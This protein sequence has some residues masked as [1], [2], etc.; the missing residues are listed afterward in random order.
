MTDLTNPL[1]QLISTPLTSLAD[2][3]RFWSSRTPHRPYL[4]SPTANLSYGEVWDRVAKIACFLRAD[5]KIQN[6]S[7]LAICVLNAEHSIYFIWASLALGICLAFV[8]Q[9]RDPSVL[10]GHMKTAGATLLLTDIPML[11]DSPFA[12]SV[13][14]LLAAIDG[15]IQRP[16]LSV[17]PASLARSP[18]FILP[19][20]GTMGE[21]K[22]V[23]LSQGQFL[24]SIL[25]LYRMGQLDRAVDRF[26]YI[27]PPLSHSYGLSTFLEYSFSGSA[28][29]VASDFSPLRMMGELAQKELSQQ[30]TALEGVPDFYRLLSKFANKVRLPALH[31][32]GCGGGALD[33]AAVEWLS[34]VYPTLSCSIRYG[35]T[36][37]PSVVAYNVVT[38]PYA[39]RWPISG[40]VLPIYEV[41]IVGESGQPLPEG[42]EGEIWLKGECLGLPYLGDRSP[43]SEY[44]ATGDLGYFDSPQS[45]VVT[46]R[47]SLF[48]KHKG[49]RLS[50]EQIESV[51]AGL[52]GILDCRV[53]SQNSELV[54]EVVSPNH[55]HTMEEIVAFLTA[56]LPPYAIPSSIR[57][58]ERLPR[59]AS[60]KLERH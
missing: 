49:F 52:A 19:T 17:A 40:K 21:P 7:V 10:Q 59:T 39:D 28:I 55:A 16:A 42:Q 34:S 60:G 58:V 12:Y 14:D 45:L 37:T 35:L 30:I 26:V 2:I 54:A 20:S 15:E 38:L 11:L 8:P 25:A 56:R 13:S 23:Q 24:Q 41:L 29:A 36:E 6:E 31:H 46:G 22:W 44:F 5:P 50:P 51:L 9:T 43:Q 47:K 32:I 48:I 33:G 53:S 1:E 4:F 57:F 3:L 27:T 18:A